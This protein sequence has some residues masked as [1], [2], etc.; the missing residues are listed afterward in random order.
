M[1]KIISIIITFFDS[2][3][4]SCTK[5][6]YIT[7]NTNI[8]DY[9]YHRFDNNQNEIDLL[10]I[11]NDYRESKGLNRLELIEHLSYMSFKH[12]EY[13][14]KNSNITHF[15]FEYRENNIKIV[16]NAISVGENIAYGYSTNISTLNSWI[17]SNSHRI[18]LERDYTHFG[19]SIL[20][21]SNNKKYYTIIFIKK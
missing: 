2:I 10:N 6:D 17:N 16:L 4:S 18:N 13:M 19:T 14:I 12:N 9:S 7:N 5:D 15:G 3:F 20:I 11:V 1:R 21:D 8:V